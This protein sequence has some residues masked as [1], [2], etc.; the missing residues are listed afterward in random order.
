MFFPVRSGPPATNDHDN[1]DHV[2]INDLTKKKFG[3]TALL[4]YV[5][6]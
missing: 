5:L 2:V 1:D 3:P 4:P 6:G